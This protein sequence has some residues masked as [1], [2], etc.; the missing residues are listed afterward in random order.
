MLYLKFSPFSD[1]HTIYIAVVALIVPDLGDLISLIG[2]VASSALALIFPPLLEILIFAKV[3][4]SIS[5]LG[6]V[7]HVAWIT[8]DLLIMILGI[9][10][11]LFGTYA[12]IDGIVNYKGADDSVCLNFF[13]H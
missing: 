7:K 10:G 5:R 11:L 8:K 6:L 3:D 4:Y 13:P 12:S 9:I 1:T 2:A